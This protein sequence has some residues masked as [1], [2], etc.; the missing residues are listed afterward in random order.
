MQTRCIILVV[1]DA[2]RP[3]GDQTVAIT[4][5]AYGSHRIRSISS[6]Y[7]RTLI[8]ITSQSYF[9]IPTSYKHI[10]RG[11][12]G[13]NTARTFDVIHSLD[14]PSDMWWWW[15]CMH[16]ISRS[17]LGRKSLMHVR[18]AESACMSLPQ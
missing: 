12:I 6:S 17:C 11:Q 9:P 3:L 15:W 7:L 13:C 2:K 1:D 5:L 4:H 16:L 14:N 10:Q 18:Q 8:S